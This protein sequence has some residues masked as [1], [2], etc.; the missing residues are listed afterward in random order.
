MLSPPSH[1]IIRLPPQPML[2]RSLLIV[3]RQKTM[4]RTMWGFPK[5][6]VILACSML[7]SSLFVDSVLCSTIRHTEVDSLLERIATTGPAKASGDL[8]GTLSRV[9][10]QDFRRALGACVSGT[11]SLLRVST[12]RAALSDPSVVVVS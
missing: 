10:R 4:A 12:T 1:S 11:P 7:A 5:F 6:Q 3:A 2:A 8:G 9:H